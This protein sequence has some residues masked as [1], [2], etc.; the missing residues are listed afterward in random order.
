M[1][2]VEGPEE[3]RKNVLWGDLPPLRAFRAKWPLCPHTTTSEQCICWHLNSHSAEYT[4][5]N[6]RFHNGGD[7]FSM[8]VNRV[9]P[10]INLSQQPADERRN[11]P[12]TSGQL[13]AGPR[14]RDPFTL[15]LILE[16]P[17]YL[18]CKN[19]SL[20]CGRKPEYPER[21]HT[22]TERTCN[23]SSVSLH[24]DNRQKRH[25]FI[26]F[27]RDREEW[28]SPWMLFSLDE[29]KRMGWLR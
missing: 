22:D 29:L 8:V 12:W 13:I 15:E 21:T 20:G 10:S 25:F 11:T 6:C 2:R 3:S 9:Y 19:L 16:S 4:H 18:S 26:T 27:E 1:E 5:R 23:S 28:E 14:E 24:T 7:V 17:V